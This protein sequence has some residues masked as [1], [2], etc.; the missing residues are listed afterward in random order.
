[1][2]W[3]IADHKRELPGRRW[4]SIVLRSLHLLGIAGIAGGYLYQLPLQQWHGWLML[5]LGSGLLMLLKEIY[6]DGIWL[7]QLRGQVVLLKMLLL[8]CSHLWWS[9]PQAWAYGLIILISGLISHAPGNVR[10]YSPWYRCRLSR[11]LW[12]TIRSDSTE[13]RNHDGP[14]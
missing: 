3:L 7:L 14:G 4:I 2:G 5:A 9:T 6:V 1:M 13:P 11:E 10:Y 8:G 12:M